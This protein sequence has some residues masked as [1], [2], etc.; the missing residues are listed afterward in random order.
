VDSQL[1]I[2][3]KTNGMKSVMAFLIKAKSKYWV[4][5]LQLK[6]NLNMVT[7]FKV[8]SPINLNFCRTCK[9]L[10]PGKRARWNLT[11]SR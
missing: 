1:K 8:M 7:K 11:W 2:L 5:V 6:L 3:E 10:L 9:A 4:L